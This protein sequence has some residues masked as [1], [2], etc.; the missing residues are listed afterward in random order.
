ME[1]IINVRSI[2]IANSHIIFGHP[3]K[4][5]DRRLRE[6]LATGTELVAVQKSYFQ[7]VPLIWAGDLNVSRTDGK[8]RDAIFKSGFYAPPD[9]IELPTNIM[10]SRPYDQIL[11]SEV[12]REKLTFGRFGTFNL[13]EYIFREQDFDDY[14]IDIDRALPQESSYRTNDERLKYYEQFYRKFQI[15]DHRLKWAEFR[16]DW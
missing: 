11:V 2:N 16:V 3:S 14:K 8:E 5:Y 9:L 15:S 7:K 4:N 6:I 10:G 13:F 12:D 1:F